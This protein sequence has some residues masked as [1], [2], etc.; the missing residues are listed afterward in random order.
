MTPAGLVLGLG[1][2]IVALM[3]ALPIILIA[4]AGYSVWKLRK[5]EEWEQR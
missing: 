1:G 5:D 3:V 4:L 2:L